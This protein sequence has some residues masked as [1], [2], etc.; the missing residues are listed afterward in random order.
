MESVQS[1]TI[2][3]SQAKG[4]G[5]EMKQDK[6]VLTLALLLAAIFGP[7]IAA[8]QSAMPTADQTIQLSAFGAASGDYTGLSGGKNLGMTFGV[9]LALPPLQ[10]LRP[11][12]EMRGTYPID[13]G[14]IVS[15]KDAMGGLRLDF[16]LGHRAHPYGDFLFGRGE[17]NYAPP[18]YK[19]PLNPAPGIQQFYYQ[20]STTY[21][22]SPGAGFDFDIFSHFAIKVDGQVQR[23]SNVPNPSG[24]T[25][26][27]VGTIGLVYRFGKFGMP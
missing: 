19:Y 25:Y 6:S 22:Y 16:C 5:T 9:D 27:S 4:P 1:S 10:R 18:G 8:A 15:Q 26:S 3:G 12:F 24:H 17:M 20:V 23:W 11:V 14:T 7:G 21:I 2:S 13:K